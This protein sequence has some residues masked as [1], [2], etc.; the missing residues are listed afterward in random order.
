MITAQRPAVGSD[1]VEVFRW[2]RA[3]EGISFEDWYRALKGET[4]LV[5]QPFQARYTSLK[6][7]D[8]AA[9]NVNFS[10]IYISYAFGYRTDVSEEVFLEGGRSGRLG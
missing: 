6:S 2:V 5:N 9:D 10:S 7:L 1:P 3:F 4:H 8:V